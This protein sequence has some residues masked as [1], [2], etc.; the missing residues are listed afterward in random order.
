MSAFP[1]SSKV[2]ADA[3]YD[4]TKIREYNRKKG[5]RSEI[6]LNIRNRRKKK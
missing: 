6:P 2:T 1:R 5:I 3:M 4:T